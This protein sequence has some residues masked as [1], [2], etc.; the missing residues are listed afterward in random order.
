MGGM[1]R[2]DTPV[3][4][5]ESLGIPKKSSNREHSTLRT[6]LCPAAEIILKADPKSPSLQ[7]LSRPVEQRDLLE[8]LVPFFADLIN[9]SGATALADAQ[10]KMTLQKKQFRSGTTPQVRKMGG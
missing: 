2:L 7:S 6:L 9:C 5:Y 10:A 3:G 8:D 1:G 4:F